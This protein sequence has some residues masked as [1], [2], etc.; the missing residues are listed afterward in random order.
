[1]HKYVKLKEVGKGAHGVVYLARV[2]KEYES[3]LR[4]KI[5]ANAFSEG[6]TLPAAEEDYEVLKK[7]KLADA[8]QLER[9]DNNGGKTEDDFLKV[10]IK[11][12][13]MRSADEGVSMEAL[14][15]IKLLSEL[16]HPN[17]IRALDIFNHKQNIHLVLDFMTLDL[18]QIIQSKNI[19]LSPDDVRRYLRMILLAIEHCHTNWV[20]HRDIKPANFLVGS[21]GQLQLADFG[22]AKI[23]G[24]PKR[25]MTPRSCTLWYRAPELL[26]GCNFYGGAVDMWSVGCVFAEMLLRRPLFGGRENTEMSQLGRIFNVMGTPNEAVW[27][28]VTS[29]PTFA[30]FEA[31]PPKKWAEVFPAASEHT[32]DLVQGLL[33]YPAS[34]RLSATEAL[35][36]PYFQGDN[37]VK[38]V[39]R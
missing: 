31:V 19:V 33:C 12:I 32:L 27:K 9:M 5:G 38:K 22:L 4:A 29:L 14:R 11:K 2:Q 13:Y 20:L 23:Y 35:Q 7:R 28:G 26:Y 1:M 21:N 17:I 36:H 10:A 3:E 24:T 16:H 34:E 30:E 25:V 8:S 37:N 15:E 39:K 18:E 6:K